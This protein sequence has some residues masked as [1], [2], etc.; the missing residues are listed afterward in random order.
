ML[1]FAAEAVRRALRRPGELACA[2]G[3]SLS[4]PK[5]RTWF[6]ASPQGVEGRG[7]QLDRRTRMMYD[8]ANV[9]INGESFAA[10]AAMAR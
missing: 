2:L 3:E 5:A 8:A 6:E 4:E 1:D 10:R 9:Y 7:L